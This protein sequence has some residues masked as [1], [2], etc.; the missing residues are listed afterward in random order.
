MTYSIILLYFLLREGRWDGGTIRESGTER[1]RERI[2]GL[3]FCVF[4]EGRGERRG[5]RRRRKRGRH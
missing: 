2:N 5:E 3:I 1:E 4:K